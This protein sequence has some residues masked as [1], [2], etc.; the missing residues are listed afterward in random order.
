MFTDPEAFM[1]EDDLAVPARC[2]LHDMNDLCRNSS[3]LRSR[4]C[5]NSSPTFNEA[6]FIHSSSRLQPLNSVYPL[7]IVSG[8]SQWIYR[9]SPGPR[10]DVHQTYQ[11]RADGLTDKPLGIRDKWT[12]FRLGCRLG[13]CRV[14]HKLATLVRHDLLEIR[15]H[16]SSA[17]LRSAAGDEVKCNMLLKRLVEEWWKVASLVRTS[18]LLPSL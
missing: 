2:I 18:L 16:P 8:P 6:S 3:D 1:L 9:G 13:L 17:V 15:L 4:H 7:N 14:L 10:L 5:Q 12:R 11:P